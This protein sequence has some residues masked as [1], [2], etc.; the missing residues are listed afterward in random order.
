MA[1][2]GQRMVFEDDYQYLKDLRENHQ[3]PSAEWG[4][5]SGSKYTS[6]E[7]IY[8][9]N[10]EKTINLDYTDSNTIEFDTSEGRLWPKVKFGEGLN[11]DNNGLYVNLS[12]LNQPVTTNNYNGYSIRTTSGGNTYTSKFSSSALQVTEPYYSTIYKTTGIDYFLDQFIDQ[13]YPTININAGQPGQTAITHINIPHNPT[14]GTTVTYT[15]ATTD[16]LGNYYNKTQSDNKYVSKANLTDYSINEIIVG[17][18]QVDS[19]T[20]DLKAVYSQDVKSEVSLQPTSNI[21]RTMS[22]TD[23]S[24]IGISATEIDITTPMLKYGTNEVA[25]KNDIPTTA[26]ST[27]TVTPTTETFTF[28]YDDDTTAT[29]TVLTGASV[30][31]TTTLS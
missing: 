21:I 5:G 10:Q 20:V 17:N 1:N 14:A 6:G 16:D 27:S 12:N 2:K 15:L 9:D 3:D 28:T 11:A 18:S 22:G 13:N 30:S 24:T 25:T 26:T 8:V 4:G 31:T 23:V 29:I 7:F 19:D